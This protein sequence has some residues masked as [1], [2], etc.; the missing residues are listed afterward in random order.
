M[1]TLAA[2]RIFTWLD[3]LSQV[4][5]ERSLIYGPVGNGPSRLSH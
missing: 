3:R 5:E 2:S 1:L 4:E